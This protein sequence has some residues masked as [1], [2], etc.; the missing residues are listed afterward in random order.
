[1]G[2]TESKRLNRSGGRMKTSKIVELV[3]SLITLPIWLYLM[4]WVI[5]QSNP[6][7]LIWFLFWSYV[8]LSILII[9][10]SKAV[11]DD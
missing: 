1:M 10:I 5:G 4:Y 9:I 6:D 7:R 11:E 2:K 8:P 3:G